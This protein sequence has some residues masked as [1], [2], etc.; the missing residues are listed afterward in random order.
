MAQAHGRFAG[1]TDQPKEEHVRIATYTRI[2]T[3]EAHQPYSLSSQA[4]RLASYIDSQP[5][6]TLT[7]EFTDQM[8][9]AVLERPGLERALIEARAHRYDLL[10][11]YRVDRLARSVRTLAHILEEL[12]E[13]GVAFRSAT[14]PFDTSTPGG[15]MFVQMLGVFAEFERATIVERVIAGMERKAAT[16]GWPG[17]YRPFG[18]EP[19]PETGL[20]V[21]KEDEAPLVPIIFELYANKRL[22]S[23]ATAQWLNRRG[24]RTKSGRPW[25]HTAVITVITNRVYVGEIFF[26]GRYHPAPHPR[27]VETRVFETTQAILESRGEDMALRRTNGSDYLLTGLLVCEKCGKRFVGASA[28]GNAYRY[29]YYVCFSRHRYGTQECDQDRLRADELEDRVV[30]SLLATLARRDLLKDAVDRWGEIVETTRPSRERELAAAEAQI[31]KAQGSLDR[32]FHAFEEGR[33]REEVCTRR[34][35]ELS[36]ELTSLEA[37]R[38]DLAEEASESQPGVPDPAQLGELVEDIERALRDG[39]LPERKA[40]MQA[41]VAEVRVRDRG[42]IQPVFRVP[43]FGPPYRSVPPAGIEPATRGLG[44]RCSP[45]GLPARTR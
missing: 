45:D 29:A 13:A 23:R 30:E 19:D 5:G 31:R 24:H 40:V 41:V 12:D 39:A 8:T 38:S 15:R 34:I 43:V 28:K 9:G 22:G 16:G 44:I 3:D 35:E 14:E 27:L 26:R 1:S 10:L 2:S 37:R 33:L 21:V 36:A 6:W 4:E 7:R 17:G 20:L 11:V 18:Y 25:S 42:H 32:Y